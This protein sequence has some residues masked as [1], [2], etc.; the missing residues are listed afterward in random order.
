MAASPAFAATPRVSVARLTTGITTRDTSVAT[1]TTVV[2][3]PT[4]G[5]KVNRIVVKGETDP[6]DCVV[7]LWL[8]I[9]GTWYLWKEIDLDNPAAGSTTVAAWEYE[10]NLADRDIVLPDAVLLGATITVTPTVG[11]VNIF[12]FCGDF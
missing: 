5:C 3:P 11:G 7:L 2:D 9:A 4:N 1:P 12:A 8:Q 10:L 6:A